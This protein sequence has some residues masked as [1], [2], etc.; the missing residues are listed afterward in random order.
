MLGLMSLA[1]QGLRFG[2]DLKTWVFRVRESTAKLRISSS[3]CDSWVL[4]QGS[5]IYLAYNIWGCMR[6][7]FY[8]H[9]CSC[10]Q[11]TYLCLCLYPVDC[12]VWGLNAL[13]DLCAPVRAVCCT[14]ATLS[15]TST[16]RP[17]QHQVSMLKASDLKFACLTRRSQ[18][19]PADTCR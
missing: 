12:S 15:P 11:F 17:C 4:S 14:A 6:H 8:M 3:L 9:I 19:R 1:P 16:S 2:L 13:N 18:A 7:T 10:T 5:S